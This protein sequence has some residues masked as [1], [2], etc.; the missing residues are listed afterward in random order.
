MKKENYRHEKKNAKQKEKKFS[1]MRNPEEK[2]ENL[3]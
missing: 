3:A 1:K 2:F